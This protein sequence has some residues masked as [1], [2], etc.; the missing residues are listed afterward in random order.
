MMESMAKAGVEM[1][2][3]GIAAMAAFF[4]SKPDSA[5]RWATRLERTGGDGG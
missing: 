1:A 4:M 2:A 3:T 5:M